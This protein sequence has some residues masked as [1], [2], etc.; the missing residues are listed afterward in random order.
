MNLTEGVVE[1]YREPTSEGYGQSVRLTRGDEVRPV[2]FPTLAVAIDEVLP[3]E[4]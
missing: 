1:V 4:A 3:A 2:R